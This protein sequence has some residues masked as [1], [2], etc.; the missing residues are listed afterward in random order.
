ME[1]TLHDQDTPTDNTIVTDA[2]DHMDGILYAQPS[3]EGQSTIP[4]G[5]AGYVV[6]NWDDSGSPS[7]P[8]SAQNSIPNEVSSDQGQLTRRIMKCI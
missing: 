5:R 7:S 8:Q 4:S 2:P 1:V 6:Q 3:H